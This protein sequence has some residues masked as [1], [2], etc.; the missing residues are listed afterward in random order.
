MFYE[1]VYITEHDTVTCHIVIRQTTISTS[2]IAN[3]FQ[4]L[5]VL[6]MHTNLGYFQLDDL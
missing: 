2:F 6:K 4:I 5:P 3:A 1:T